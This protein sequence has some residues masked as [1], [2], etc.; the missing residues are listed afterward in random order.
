MKNTPRRG[1]T[2]TRSAGRWT[3]SSPT[4]RPPASPSRGAATTRRTGLRTSCR[5]CR[6]EQNTT[7]GCS[8]TI[9]TTKPLTKSTSCCGSRSCESS[10]AGQSRE[11]HGEAAVLFS[12]LSVDQAHRVGKEKAHEYPQANRLHRHVC[13]TGRAHGSA[14][15][16]D[17]IVP[18]DRPAG[19]PQERKR[20]GCR[21]VGIPASGLSHSRGLFSPQCAPYARVLRS[22][23]GIP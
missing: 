20:R 7:T 9:M 18:R 1:E 3:T 21:S 19:Q 11:E 13:R 15:P 2:S 8:A 5:R 10:E 23:R 22:L 4:A 12:A 16:A 14:A 17:G 6:K